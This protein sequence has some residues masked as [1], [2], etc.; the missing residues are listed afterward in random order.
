MKAMRN[1]SE[2]RHD[3]ARHIVRVPGRPRRALRRRV[4][5]TSRI[6]LARRPAAPSSIVL[7]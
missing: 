6:Q 7:G 3:L 4:A 5:T 2:G 1:L